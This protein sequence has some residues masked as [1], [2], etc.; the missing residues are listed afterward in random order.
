MIETLRLFCRRVKTVLSGAPAEADSDSRALEMVEPPVANAEIALSKL[1]AQ[2]L[3]TTDET[4]STDKW[5]V[6]PY[7]D[8]VFEKIG[9]VYLDNG[10]L[11]IRS[12][13]DHRG[14]C[15]A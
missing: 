2:V 6:T 10:D 12:D 5:T 13:R 1:H 14:L 8:P 11:V 7:R 3:S 9:R 4:T 15:F